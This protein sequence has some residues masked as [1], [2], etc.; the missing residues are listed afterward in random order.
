MTIQDAARLISA[1]PLTKNARLDTE[2]TCGYACDLL[3]FVMANGRPGM[4]W[5]T[6]QLNM[7]V[8]AVAVLADMACVILPQSVQMEPPV[9]QKAEDEGICVLQSAKNAYE[10]CGIL[11]Q[12]G[13]PAGA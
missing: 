9:L 8:I 12:N 4:A 7:N 3:S 10:I 6:V 13:L 11:Y 1:Q 2:L 5:V